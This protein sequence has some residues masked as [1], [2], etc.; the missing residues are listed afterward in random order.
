MFA[1]KDSDSSSGNRDSWFLFDSVIICDG[2]DCSSG[3]RDSG[4]FFDTVFSCDESDSS[5]TAS[6]SLIS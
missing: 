3:N 5:S 1:C 4:L 2:S 6:L